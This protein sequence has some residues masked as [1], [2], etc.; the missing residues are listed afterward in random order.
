VRSLVE[1]DVER[2][3]AR[4]LGAFG[5]VRHDHLGVPQGRVVGGRPGLPVHHRRDSPHLGRHRDLPVQPAREIIDA[6]PER[7]R[8][9]LGKM[10][11]ISARDQSGQQVVGGRW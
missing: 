6:V 8:L 7:V 9:L 10:N 2:V 4:M 3:D 1:A 11:Q 5:H